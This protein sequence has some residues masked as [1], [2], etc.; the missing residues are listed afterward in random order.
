MD[1]SLGLWI[2]PAALL[3]V[4]VILL[5]YLAILNYAPVRR[6]STPSAPKQ[7]RST[8]TPVENPVVLAP[9]PPPMP[10]P[11]PYRPAPPPMPSMP[12]MYSRPPDA[13]EL[14]TMG[15]MIIIAGLAPR[16]IPLPSAQFGIGRFYAPENNV[17]VAVDEKS[18]SRKHATMR[19]AAQGREYYIQDVGSSY[20]THLIA[21]GRFDRLTPG[22]EERV[23]NNDVIQFGSAVQVRLVL[24]C[25]TRSATTQL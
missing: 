17:L 19:I 3:V 4:T 20:G 7:T 8:V 21:E 15:K 1:I 16:E 12:P 18:V 13:T 14:E 24:P 2:L 9:P 25:E 6:E 22:R 5:L 11:A 23:Y 10:A